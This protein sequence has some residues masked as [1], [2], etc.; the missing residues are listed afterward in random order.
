MS[1]LPDIGTLARKSAKADLRGPRLEGWGG[2][3]VG[4]ASLRD[5]PHHEA[6]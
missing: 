3:M 1:G 6:D 4:D 2:H 5:A